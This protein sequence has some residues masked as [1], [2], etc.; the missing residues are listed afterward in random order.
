M[1]YIFPQLKGL[2]RSVTSEYYG[3]DGIS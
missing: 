1:W 2:G 3:I